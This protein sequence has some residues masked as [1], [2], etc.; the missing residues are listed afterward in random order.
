MATPWEK[1]DTRIIGY[2]LKAK[3]PT[4]HFIQGRTID[5]IDDSLLEAIQQT[6]M[7]WAEWVEDEDA[8]DGCGYWL[9]KNGTVFW[10][11]D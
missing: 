2:T 7:E 8:P 6:L 10:F 4:A 5:R 3:G 9:A 11:E 1:T